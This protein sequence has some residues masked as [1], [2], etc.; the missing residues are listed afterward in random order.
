M[1]SSGT[2][3]PSAALL[4][5]RQCFEKAVEK[6]RRLWVGRPGA[7]RSADHCIGQRRAN[8]RRGVVIELEVL[9]RCAVPVE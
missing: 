1:K 4:S 3:L 6:R 8:A 5:F 2:G 7:C 9:G